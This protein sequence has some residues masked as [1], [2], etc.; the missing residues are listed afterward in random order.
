MKQDRPLPHNAEI[1]RNAIAAILREPDI[2][3]AGI[4]QGLTAECFY[5]HQ[6]R[7]IYS[8]ILDMHT[9]KDCIDIVSVSNILRM[10]KKIEE[11]ELLLAEISGSIATAVNFQGWINTLVKLNA[12]RQLIGKCLNTAEVC[13]RDDCK[14][15]DIV[16]KH[17]AEVSDIAGIIEQ[18]RSRGTGQILQD[19]LQMFKD[20]I[21]GAQIVRYC[22]P[23]IDAAIMH[24]RQMMHVLS[25]FPGIG[26]TAWAL[27]AMS[28]QIQHDIISVIF[29][30]ESSSQETGGKLISI[31]SGIPYV[32]MATG[33]NKIYTA[34]MGRFESAVNT[35]KQHENN[36]F[37]LGGR[38]YRHSI[39]GIRTELKRILDQRGRIDAVYVDYLQNMDAPE[40]LIRKD[41]TPQVEY[42]VEALKNLFMEF[43]CAGTVLSQISREGA[44]AE[45]PKMQHLKYASAIEAEAHIISFLYRD[46]QK[47]D[48]RSVLET[49]WYSEKTRI[50]SPFAKVLMFEKSIAK[51]RGKEFS[52][53]DRP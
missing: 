30:K 27:S 32:K 51:Y 13:F 40:H 12:K 8:V 33:F 20:G 9:E 53:E 37:I 24:G 10:R 47:D 52:E 44:K 16:R 38:D 7:E 4:T 14:I 15:K 34:D 49:E 50:Q 23:S 1:E 43:N 22:I 28:Q 18:T 6:H 41:K 48:P 26:K 46:S 39:A 29:C 11:P 19:T 25:A 21:D 35:L 31:L 17:S 42:N 3:D 45:R 36:L 2:I 5:N